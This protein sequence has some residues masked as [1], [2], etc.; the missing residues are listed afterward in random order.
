MSIETNI[1]KQHQIERPKKVTEFL[2]ASQD[3]DPMLYPG[4]RPEQSYLT[5]GSLVYEL[6]V[7]E[8]ENLAFTMRTEDGQEIDMNDFL[9][10]HNA[11]LLEDR[12][13]VLGFGANMSPGSLASKFTKVGR[14]DAFVVPT[15]Y[16]TLKDHDVVW[17]G[18][19]GMNGNFI[20]VL[21]D[22]PEVKDTEVQ[23][24]V[25]FLTREQLL[26]MNATE[27]AY[28]LAWADVSIEGHPV[29]AYYYVGQDQIYIKDGAPVAIESVPATGRVIDQSNTKALLEDIIDNKA[30]TEKVSELFPGISDVETTDDYI[31]LTK[32]LRAQ[33]ISLKLKKAVHEAIAEEGLARK[34]EPEGFTSRMESWANPS[35]LPTLGDQQLGFFHHPVYRLPTQELGEWKDTEAR[36]RLLRSITAHLVRHSGGK[37]KIQP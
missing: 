11:P 3:K 12:I 7:Q 29:R 21:Y 31:D 36:D 15:A 34:V 19:P 23:V 6:E 20:A 10:E 4:R 27:M 5:D 9:R 30:I 26:V 25:N 37:L 1:E 24:G 13:P 2:S 22:G 18:G 35:T 28:Q 17:S 33:K 32:E 8:T 16:T 14:E